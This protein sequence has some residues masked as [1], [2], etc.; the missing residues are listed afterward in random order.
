[1][2]S[3]GRACLRKIS[4]DAVKK[5]ILA[6]LHKNHSTSSAEATVN[7]VLEMMRL[8]A[9]VESTTV[10]CWLAEKPRFPPTRWWRPGTASST[11]PA[12]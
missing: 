7:A 9:L 10:P 5:R 1:M 6:F 3:L 8:A 12:L 4:A 11:C 2:V